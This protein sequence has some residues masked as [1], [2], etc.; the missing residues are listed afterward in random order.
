MKQVK[1]FDAH[2]GCWACDIDTKR[3]LK[4]REILQRAKG[5]EQAIGSKVQ[6]NLI[7]GSNKRDITEWV[8]RMG[9]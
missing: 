9:E 2:G 4:F 1:F 8:W 6:I 7:E 3:G 5:I